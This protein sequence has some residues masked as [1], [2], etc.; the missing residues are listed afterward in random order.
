[1][2]IER[3]GNTFVGPAP[4]YGGVDTSCPGSHLKL[5]EVS[6][7]PIVM[8]WQHVRCA[9]RMYLCLHCSLL[10]HDDTSMD[11]L[12]STAVQCASTCQFQPV[13]GFS[14]HLPAVEELKNLL[15][16]LV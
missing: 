9:A 15:L 12:L 6:G 2:E 16:A 3:L 14:L 5:I 10:G 7:G 4:A 13:G 1:M 11:L 8:D